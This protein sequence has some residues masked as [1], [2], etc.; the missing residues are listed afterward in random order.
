MQLLQQPLHIQSGFLQLSGDRQPDAAPSEKGRLWYDPAA[1]LWK[2]SADGSALEAISYP[3]GVWCRDFEDFIGALQ[4]DVYEIPL[5]DN[6]NEQNTILVTDTGV[7]DG[8]CR[9]MRGGIIDQMQLTVED[10]LAADGTNFI[11]FA[12][13]NKLAG[14]AGAIAVLAATDANTTKAA[15]TNGLTAFA[16]AGLTASATEENRYVHSGDVLH[17]TATVSGTLPNAV[18]NP[19]LRIQVRRLPEKL[20]GFKLFGAAPTGVYPV[21]NSVNGEAKII[22]NATSEANYGGF[23]YGGNLQIPA[24]RGPILTCRLKVSGVAASTRFIWGL[25]SG[26]NSTMDNVASHAW[27]RLEGDSL[28][29]VAE[30]DD[31]TTDNDD[32]ATGITLVADTYALFKIDLASKAG[33]A[34]F[35]VNGVQVAELACSAL[36]VANVW[37]PLFFHQKDSGTSALSMTVDM[38][39]PVWKRE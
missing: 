17:I 27:F 22:M 15:G 38:Y 36:T 18:D 4:F 1:D 12:I 3:P 32:Q 33:Y 13:T 5:A 20:N 31:G 19:V 21:N 24:S 29:L 30:T 26:I 25:A 6:T 10:S 8:L 16:S 37:E 23:R 14:G 28:A 34:R 35:S 7:S 2:V 39:E 11:T 9:I